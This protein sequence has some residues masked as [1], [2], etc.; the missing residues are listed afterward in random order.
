MTTG[1]LGWFLWKQCSKQG[2]IWLDEKLVLAKKVLSKR[3]QLTY[4]TVRH[5]E[6]HTSRLA[7]LQAHLASAQTLGHLTLHTARVSREVITACTHLN[8]PAFYP[9]C[10]YKLYII[11]TNKRSFRA[12]ALTGPPL[13]RDEVCLLSD[14]NWSVTFLVNKLAVGQ[15]LLKVQ[16]FSRQ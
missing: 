11:L 15:V 1:S 12:K 5:T 9:Q 14:K 4:W 3:R 10:I 6:T 16:R 13:N 8:K 7:C 2:T